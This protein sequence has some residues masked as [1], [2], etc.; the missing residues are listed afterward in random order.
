MTDLPVQAPAEIVIT[1]DRGGDFYGYFD[2]LRRLTARGTHVRI[3]GICASACTMLLASP[4]ACVGPHAQFWFHA[5]IGS[6]RDG[7]KA[8]TELMARQWPAPVRAWLDR[9]GGLSPIVRHL[10]G[11][12]LRMMGLPPCD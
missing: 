5:V 4:G 12:D 7:D 6:S 8:L 10:R 2:L 11:P 9:R 1:D 3:E